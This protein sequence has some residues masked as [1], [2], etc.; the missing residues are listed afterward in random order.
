MP[1]ASGVCRSSGY[2]DPGGCPR[3]QGIAGSIGRHRLINTTSDGYVHIG[4][5]YSS[6]YVTNQPEKRNN[7]PRNSLRLGHAHDWD[8][9]AHHCIPAKIA[10]IGCTDRMS[11][12]CCPALCEWYRAFGRLHARRD[13]EHHIGAG[14]R[15][16]LRRRPGLIHPH[17]RASVGVTTADTAGWL[18]VRHP[19]ELHHLLQRGLALGVLV[20]DQLAKSRKS[21]DSPSSSPPSMARTPHDPK[22]AEVANLKADVARLTAELESLRGHIANRTP[23]ALMRDFRGNVNMGTWSKDDDL[24]DHD[25]NALEQRRRVVGQRQQASRFLGEHVADRAVRLVGTA[26]VGGRAVAPDLGLG[27]EVTKILEAAGGK[28]AIA[29][30]S[31]GALDATLLVAASDRDRARFKAIMPGKAQQGRMKRIASPRRSS[32]TLLMSSVG[33]GNAVPRAKRG[34]VAAQEVLHPGV[35]EEAQEDLPRMAQHHHERHQRA[36]CAA[37]REMAEMSPVHL[38]LLTRQAM[39]AWL[40]NPSRYPSRVWQAMFIFG[41]RAQ[42]ADG[43]L[44]PLCHRP[45]LDAP[46][47]IMHLASAT[48]Y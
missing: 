46:L 12:R 32:T 10:L 2:R 25:C 43:A 5:I 4:N 39:P 24:A 28:E 27:I 8:I 16:R 14:H 36:P 29:D 6:F 31:D 47:K 22:D 45:G 42:S 7:V 37:D 38:R 33:T 40:C 44:G 15:P 41:F 26:P 13:D 30:V 3:H 35:Q 23:L 9:T 17:M 11:G 21:A 34:D 19:M 18:E 1:A 20:P 48:P